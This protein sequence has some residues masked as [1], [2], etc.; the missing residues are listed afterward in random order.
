MTCAIGGPA[1]SENVY[2]KIGSRFEQP[3]EFYE[4]DGDPWTLPVGTVV[5]LVFGD[6]VA[7]LETWTATAAGNTALFARTAAQ[8]A[9]ARATIPAGSAA[10]IRM[11][12]P[13]ATDPDVK[14][15]GM[16]VWQ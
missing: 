13:P 15:V 6:P 10:R 3:I 5:E 16:V 4:T 8:I 11:T 14:T 7:P 9:A 2:L 1:G 12:V